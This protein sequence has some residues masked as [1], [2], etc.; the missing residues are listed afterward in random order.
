[1]G[2]EICTT[3]PHL[4]YVCAAAGLASFKSDAFVHVDCDRL[5]SGRVSHDDTTGDLADNPV[6]CVVGFVGFFRRA[7]RKGLVVGLLPAEAVC[8]RSVGFV[9]CAAVV[10]GCGCVGSVGFEW[11]V[12]RAG[13]LVGEQ[14]ASAGCAGSAGEQ[15]PVGEQGPAGACRLVRRE[16]PETAGLPVRRDLSGANA[17]VDVYDQSVVQPALEDVAAGIAA[18]AADIAALDTLDELSCT[19]TQVV[20][21][22]SGWRCAETVPTRSFKLQSS[23]QLHA[24]SHRLL[25]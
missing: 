1:M 5:T 20:I 2:S 13:L 18:N 22:D 19:A 23:H 25:R 17:S 16:I 14:F 12:W 9:G 7:R 3:R 6:V 8:R 15:G 10:V 11:A 24:R 4:V 21:N